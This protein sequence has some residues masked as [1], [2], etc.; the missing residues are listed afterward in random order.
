MDYKERMKAEYHQLKD[1]YRKLVVMVAKYEA[2]TLDFTPNCPL[3]LLKEQKEIM[4]KYL[5]VLELR[6]EIERVEL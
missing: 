6:A 2:G 5:Q 3:E 4:E 1:R